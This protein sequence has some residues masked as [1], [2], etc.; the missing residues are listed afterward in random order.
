M[1]EVLTLGMSWTTSEGKVESPGVG[2][3]NVMN[4][5]E[6]NWLLQTIKD[7]KN[8]ERFVLALYERG[9]ISSQVMDEVA[10]ERGWLHRRAN[11]FLTM[12]TRRLTGYGTTEMP[13]AL[14]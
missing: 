14:A 10:R 1:T 9:R 2:K 7:A 11:R 12:A 3:E 4:G 8:A 6:V 5:E 13:T